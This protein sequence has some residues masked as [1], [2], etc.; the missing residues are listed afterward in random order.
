M[1]VKM[2]ETA[3]CSGSEGNIRGW[4]NRALIG[5]EMS[6]DGTGP[7]ELCEPFNGVI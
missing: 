1:K 2:L 4:M 3:C 5:D 6:P 7:E